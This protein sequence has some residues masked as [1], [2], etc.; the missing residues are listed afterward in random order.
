VIVVKGNCKMFM[1]KGTVPFT[2]DVTQSRISRTP[3]PNWGGPRWHRGPKIQSRYHLAP[4]RKLRI[5]KLKHESPKK[6]VKLGA[7]WKKRAYAIYSY[8]GP[9]WKQGIFTFQLLL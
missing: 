7:F 3:Y 6:F 2:N 9:I 5:T 4:Y 8:F 1:F